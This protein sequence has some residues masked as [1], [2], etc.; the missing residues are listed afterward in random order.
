MKLLGI[1]PSNSFLVYEGSSF[2][3]YP[4][5]PAPTLVAVSI[6]DESSDTL[7]PGV[8]QR[9]VT[10]MDFVLVD[11]GYDPTSR[12]RKG[13]LFKRYEGTQPHSWH[14]LPH[15]AIPFEKQKMDANGVFEK[16][17]GTYG[18]F[19]LTSFLKHKEIARPLFLLGNEREFTIWSL[20]E[21]EATVSGVPL[22][23]LKSRKIFGALPR[24]K[25]D[26]IPEEQLFRLQDKLATLAEDLYRAGPESVIDRC[27][28]AATA[29][30]SAYLHANGCGEKGKDLGALTNLFESRLEDKKDIVI[31]LGRTLARLHA[32]GKTAEQERRSVRQSSEQ[33]AELAVQA[34]G[35]ILRDLG[36]AE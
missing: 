25:A 15:P 13:R 8:N 20:V 3:G 23:Y 22:V 28:E 12:V 5:W 19:G 17:L 34:V 7:E 31:N 10:F 14:V 24:L 26:S 11:E 36:W 29:I 35:L 2:W 33:D 21:V 27:R 1:D 9:D 32:R 6:V 30:L 4:I 18:D 16:R